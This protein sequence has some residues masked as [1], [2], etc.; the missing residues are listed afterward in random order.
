MRE[1]LRFIVPVSRKGRKGD[2]KYAEVCVFENCK[3]DEFIY[4]VKI[5]FLCQTTNG[6]KNQG[7]Y[8]FG[9]ISFKH[10]FLH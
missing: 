7:D 2:A 8:R 6:K 1:W 10:V 4:P 9:T 5:T 3:I